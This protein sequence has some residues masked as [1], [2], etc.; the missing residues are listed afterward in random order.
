VHISQFVWF[1]IGALAACQDESV[2]GPFGLRLREQPGRGSVA[3]L[4]RREVLKHPAC[5]ATVPPDQA[6]PVRALTKPAGRV[7][8]PPLLLGVSAPTSETTFFAPDMTAGAFVVEAPTFATVEVPED[9]PV[10]GGAVTTC[11]LSIGGAV[12]LVYLISQAHPAL[13]DDSV[14]LAFLQ[15]ADSGDHAVRAG[16]FA[17]TRA[18]RDSLMGALLRFESGHP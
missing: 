9:S 10:A 18:L 2:A 8:L 7:R 1:A 15:V 11:R 17:T 5:P 12:G 6:W 14:H 16:A 13:L 4:V 3:A